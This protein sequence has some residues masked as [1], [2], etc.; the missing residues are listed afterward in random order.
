LFKNAAQ[1]RRNSAIS[2]FNSV[3]MGWPTGLLLDAQTGRAVDENVKDNSLQIQYLT[4][5]GCNTAIKYT[6][7]ASTWTQ[8]DMD[9]WFKNTSPGNSI[10]PKAS[11][12]M[13]TD[14]FNHTGNPDY[15]P[16][17]GSPLLGSAD[18]KNS[19]LAGFTQVTYRGAVGT[20][21]TWWKGWTK[22]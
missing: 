20:G 9:T 7:G 1:I 19:K 8:T 16:Q 18:F 6:T 12:V 4:I 10:L 17:T 21:D 13:L 3:M 15:T 2:I 5:A 11:D 14:P 22:F